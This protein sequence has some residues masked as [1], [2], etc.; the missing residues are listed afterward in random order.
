MRRMRDGLYTSPDN[1]DI[2]VAGVTVELYKDGNL[3]DETTTG[4][5]GDYVFTSLPAGNYSVLVTDD[6]GVLDG[7]IDTNFPAESR[8]RQQQQASAVHH[9][10]CPIEGMNMTADFGYT[11]PGAIGDFVWYDSE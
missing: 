3:Y 6:F 10:V 11:R 2:G 7:Y 9:H 5:S 1:G 4:A 8:Q